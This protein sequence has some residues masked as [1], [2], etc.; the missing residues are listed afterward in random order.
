MTDHDRRRIY[1]L[2]FQIDANRINASG[3][4]EN[5]NK[6][7]RW[8]RDKVISINMA[9]PAQ[10]EAAYGSNNRARKAYRYVFTMTESRTPEEQGI[11]K[12]IERVL[13]PEGASTQS[14][15]ND[16]EIVFNARK[17]GCI[18][19]TNDGGSRRQPGGIL[20]NRDKL[21][22]L[23]G[24]QVLTDG[25]AV[26]LVRKLIRERDDRERTESAITG[27]PLPEWVGKD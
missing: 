10:N 12:E 2:R 1:T 5:M 15:K 7:E 25:E 24:I 16:V 3:Q 18:L 4:L 23:L 21:Q 19:V 8:R 17:Y 6:L 27:Q 22:Q 26:V 14:E 20:G 11:L 13:F 9:Q